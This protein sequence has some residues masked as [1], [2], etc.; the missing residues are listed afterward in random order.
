MWLH[1]ASSSF[2]LKKMSINNNNKPI[3][4][5]QKINSSSIDA[6][7]FSL[8]RSPSSLHPPRKIIN[9][10]PGYCIVVGHGGCMFTFDTRLCSLVAKLLISLRVPLG[11][12]T[13]KRMAWQG[14]TGHYRALQGRVPSTQDRDQRLCSLS[15]WQSLK[16]HVIRWA[17]SLLPSAHH[18]Q[19]G[20]LVSFNFNCSF[21]S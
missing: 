5:S 11:G 21:L 12:S 14:I 1:Q 9:H 17:A 15:W 20:S 10:Y 8:Y 6:H 3:R 2:F 19:P 4:K 18:H 16:G 13:E 7:S